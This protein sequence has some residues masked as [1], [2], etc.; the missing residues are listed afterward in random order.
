MIYLACPYSHDDPEVRRMRFDAANTMAA[1][2]LK[3]GDM[4]FSPLSHTHP[5]LCDKK[6]EGISHGW[7]FWAEFDTKILSVCRI[8]YVIMIDGWKQS[9]GVIAEI[10]IAKGLGLPIRGIY[11]DGTVVDLNI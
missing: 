4:V 10:G 1:I 6:A 5:I 7:D 9:K 3:K 8:L 2:L 11:L